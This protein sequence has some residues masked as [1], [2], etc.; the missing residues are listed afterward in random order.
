MR[1]GFSIRLVL[2]PLIVCVSDLISFSLS[3]SEKNITNVVQTRSLFDLPRREKKT[4]KRSLS[5]SSFFLSFL[6]F[7]LSFS[8]RR[9]CRRPKKALPFSSQAS[10]WLSDEFLSNKFFFFLKIIFRCGGCFR[11]NEENIENFCK[12]K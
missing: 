7:F 11:T 10:P 4:R 9:I 2:L 5:S 1:F 8:L 6:S 12:K 3:K